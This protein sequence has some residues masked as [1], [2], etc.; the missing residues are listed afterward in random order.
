[1]PT[2]LL[3]RVFLLLSVSFPKQLSVSAPQEGKSTERGSEA[4]SSASVM[5]GMTVSTFRYPLK[6][7]LGLQ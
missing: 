5:V 1:M 6:G 2:V 3:M 7:H 4:S